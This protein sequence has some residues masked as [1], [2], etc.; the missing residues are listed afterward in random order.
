MALEAQ[1]WM[2]SSQKSSQNEE[3]KGTQTTGKKGVA[4]ECREGQPGAGGRGRPGRAAVLGRAGRGSASRRVLEPA[5]QLMTLSGALL[6][7]I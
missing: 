6:V 7:E 5:E 1:L 2:R 4:K 3:K